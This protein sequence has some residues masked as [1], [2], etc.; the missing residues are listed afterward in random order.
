MTLE[1]LR[2]F[3]GWCTLIHMGVLILW[4]LV[5]VAGHGWLYRIHGRMFPMPESTF[6]AIHYGGLAFYKLTI[7]VFCLVP[8]VV[9]LV[10]G[11]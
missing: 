3:F 7:F 4:T 6:N 9:L 5:F 1:S 10:M 8:W 11:A 2:D